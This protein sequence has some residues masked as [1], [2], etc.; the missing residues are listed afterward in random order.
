VLDSIIDGTVARSIDSHNCTLSVGKPRVDRCGRVQECLLNLTYPTNTHNVSHRPQK[1]LLKGQQILLFPYAYHR[2]SQNNQGLGMCPTLLSYNHPLNPK[3]QHPSLP[4]PLPPPHTLSHRPLLP[5]PPS[6]LDPLLHRHL[7]HI[8][9]PLLHARALTPSQPTK[10]SEPPPLRL[11]HLL[12]S[13]YPVADYDFDL[14]QEALLRRGSRGGG[15][16]GRRKAGGGR[17]SGPSRRR[18]S[19][20]RGSVPATEHRQG[21]PKR[22][23]RRRALV[24]V[25]RENIELG[26]GEEV[27]V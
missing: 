21:I 24:V 3:L 14:L 1:P 5:P 18:R 10:A 22:V 15:G 17:V 27:V 7:H 26:G 20:R 16:G 25:V 12:I 19:T 6:R 9:I 8:L 11:R 4:T 23:F 2:R 13:V